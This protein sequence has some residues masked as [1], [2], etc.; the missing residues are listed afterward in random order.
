MIQ[1]YCHVINEKMVLEDC[2]VCGVNFGVT[3]NFHLSRKK[4]GKEFYC[5]N[6]HSLIYKNSEYDELK[7]NAKMYR[8]WYDEEVEKRCVAEGSLRATKGHLTRT[9][10][11]IS[12]GVCPCCNRNFKNL[13]AHMENKHPDYFQ[14][15]IKPL[16]PSNPIQDN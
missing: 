3:E 4:T 7:K 6:G 14:A 11:R 16:L 13:A 9:R 8:E 12:K 2:C 1:E 10:N 5:P 15:G